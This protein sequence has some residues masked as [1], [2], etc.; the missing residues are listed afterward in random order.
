MWLG[1]GGMSL[2]THVLDMAAG[3]PAEGVP[4]RLERSGGPDVAGLDVGWTAVAEVVTD[5]DG[6][7]GGLPLPA[8]GLYRLVF[9]TAARS[10]FF[11]EVVITFRVADPAQHHH[12]PLLLAP[13]GYSTYRGS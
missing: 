1:A 13:Y 3:R 4:V 11:P 9:D 7:A 10:P 2:S 6:R 5:G 12:V 8:V